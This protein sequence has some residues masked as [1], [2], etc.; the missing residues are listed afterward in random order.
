MRRAND[1]ACL[2]I[3]RGSCG[4]RVAKGELVSFVNIFGIAILA[5]FNIR[6]SATDGF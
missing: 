3:N 1:S 6:H 2:G 5:Q 4:A